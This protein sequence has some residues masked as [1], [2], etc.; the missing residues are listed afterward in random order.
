[1]NLIL[2][3]YNI[4]Q[5]TYKQDTLGFIPSFNSLSPQQ[6]VQVLTYRSGSYWYV[7]STRINTTLYYVSLQVLTA[8]SKVNSRRSSKDVS[9]LTIPFN[10]LLILIY[11]KYILPPP[12]KLTLPLSYSV[13]TCSSLAW[14]RRSMFW[15]IKW[16][17]HSL[18]S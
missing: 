17:F 11:F 6:V 18:Y 7:C 1:M 13:C 10:L 5:K 16:A 9:Y 14:L 3:E 2:K 4:I 12:S 15:L 8:T